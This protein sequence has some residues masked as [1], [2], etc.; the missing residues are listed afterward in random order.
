MAGIEATSF[1]SPD[2]TR[3]FQGHGHPEVVEL[4]GRCVFALG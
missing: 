1:N 4:H 2:A 3:Q